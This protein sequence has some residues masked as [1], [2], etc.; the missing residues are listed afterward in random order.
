MFKYILLALIPS[1][2]ILI[3]VF[4]VKSDD[5]PEVVHYA[6]GQIEGYEN[7]PEYYQV[8]M[9]PAFRWKHHTGS[10]GQVIVGVLI[11]L[12][13]AGFAYWAEESRSSPYWASKLKFPVIAVA[14][15]I[16]FLT[17]F[18]AHAFHYG[19]AQESK[20]LTVQEYEA[21]QSDL[22]AIFLK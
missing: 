7:H 16:A 6:A 18:G 21:N 10:A 3:G 14:W 13:A 22:D 17:V 8:T 1:V 11:T 2:L 19:S 12:L 15:I 4:A 9:S 5:K 20:R